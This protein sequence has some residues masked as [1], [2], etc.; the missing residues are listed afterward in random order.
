M[1][2]LDALSREIAATSDAWIVPGVAGV[3][4]D[5]RGW[6]RGSIYWLDCDDCPAS[7][8]EGDDDDGVRYV[9][10][11]THGIRPNLADA[12]TVNSLLGKGEVWDFGDYDCDWSACLDGMDNKRAATRTEAIARAWIAAHR[13]EK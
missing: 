3:T 5:G 8:E 4:P 13:G 2:D 7:E 11:E 6:R 9:A 12:V 1:T 10:S